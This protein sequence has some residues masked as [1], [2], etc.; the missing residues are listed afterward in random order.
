M[1]IEIR[2]RFEKNLKKLPYLVHAAV[3]DLIDKLVKAES[4]DK[5]GVNYTKM[6]GQKKSENYYRVRFGEYRVGVEY[7]VPNVILLR[8]IKRSDMYKHF[9]S[10]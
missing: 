8:I 2:P 7:I 6:E 3:K 1:V 4:L 5:A 10:K 9:P